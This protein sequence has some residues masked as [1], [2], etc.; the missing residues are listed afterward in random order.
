MAFLMAS[1][2]SEH[3]KEARG[4]GVTPPLPPYPPPP[5]SGTPFASTA[6]LKPRFHSAIFTEEEQE[7][8]WEVVLVMAVV[9]IRST[10]AVVVVAAVVEARII[11]V[12]TVKIIASIKRSCPVLIWK[13]GIVRVRGD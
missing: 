12:R 1:V 4:W 9:M 8:E 13:L 7:E 11:L 5:P 6:A 10:V 2:L 3:S